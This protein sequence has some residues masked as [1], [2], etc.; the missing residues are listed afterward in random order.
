MNL[1]KK[2]LLS[3]ILSLNVCLKADSSSEFQ[4]RAEDSSAQ[5]NPLLVVVIMVK[6]E[7]SVINATLEPYIKAGIDSYLIF[8]TGSTDNTLQRVQQYLAEQKVKQAHIVQEP[9]VDFATSRNRALELAE[10][11]FPNAAFLLMIDAEWYMVNVEGLLDFCKAHQDDI[12]PTYALYIKW[13]GN[14]TSYMYRLMR[15]DSRARFFGDIHEVLLPQSDKKISRDIYF[16][17]RRSEHGRTSS[18][19]RWVRDRDILLKKFTENPLDARAAFYLA[20]TYECLG[21]FH[22]AYNYYLIRSKLPGWDE[23]NYE[24]FFRLGKVTNLLSRTNEAF[25]WSMAFDYFCTAFK[26][27]PHRAEPLIEIAEHYWPDNIPLCFLFAKRALDLPYPENDILFVDSSVYDYSR[28]EVLSKSA[29]YAGEYE[30]G[31][32]A[33]RM[34]IQA[35]SDM[36]HLYRNLACY[37][38]KTGNKGS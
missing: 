4:Q 20:Q 18:G 17:H 34:A 5:Y 25:T 28:Y 23:E 9:F 6:N 22:S 26:M 29:W 7:E 33:T 13:P 37:V 3:F 31:E 15:G 14:D 12:A 19:Q 10:E 2:I 11:K 8:D 21:D 27:R 16:D 32:S 38:E 36:P 24:T 1:Y 35:R 30:L